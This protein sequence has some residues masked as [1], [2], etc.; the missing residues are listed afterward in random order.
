MLKT[1]ESKAGV[2]LYRPYT[3]THTL[4]C[5]NKAVK[6]ELP[7]PFSFNFFKTLIIV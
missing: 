4:S 3:F 7:S 2:D 5:R 1:G 6:I